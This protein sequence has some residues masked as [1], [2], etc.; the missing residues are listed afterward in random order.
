MELLREGAKLLGLTVSAERLAAFE[1]YYRE[2]ASWNS[3]FNLT[4]ITD[5]ADVQCRHFLD[6][7]SCLL[8]FPRREGEAAQ[9]P[10][11]VPLQLEPRQICLD[12][13]TGAGFPGL[14]IK[15]MLPDTRLTLLEATGKKVTFLLHMVDVLGLDDVRV[16]HGRAED[17]AHDPEERGKYD[18]VLARAV[19]SLPVLAEYCLPFCRI[20]GRFIAQKAEG[21]ADEVAAGQEAVDVLGG[22]LKERKSVAVPGIPEPRTLVVYLKARPT[23][24]DYPRRP[25]VPTRRPLG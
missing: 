1:C 20:G 2:L 13:G 11:T 7:L 5:Y 3:R 25:G 18:V 22:V 19:A 12:V 10:D 14:P 9:I 15:I 17:V 16:I 21:I 4:T 23:P 24:H 6:S 8:A